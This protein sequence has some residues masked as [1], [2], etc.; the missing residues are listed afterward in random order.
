V[1]LLLYVVVYAIMAY[2]VLDIARTPR[3]DIRM[4]SKVIWIVLVLLFF[5]L[6]SVMWF[7]FGRPRSVLRRG[8]GGF[9]LEQQQ[10]DA[11]RQHPAYGG[12]FDALATRSEGIA[13]FFGAHD[14]D[15]P[16]GPDDDPEFLREL[17]ERL[18]REN[19]EGP[20]RA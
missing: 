5:L 17:S 7:L 16:R 10:Q 8:L 15:R 20:S 12:R 4:L 2:T 9:R 13:A 18:R 19:P 1:T 3:K 11:R 6:G 14:N